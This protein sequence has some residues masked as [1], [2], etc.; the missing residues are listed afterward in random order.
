M[1][2]RSSGD[3]VEAA[4]VRKPAVTVDDL[5]LFGGEPSEP[6]PAEQPAHLVPVRAH[7]RRVPGEA[8]PSGK[9]LRDTALAAHEADEAKAVAIAYLRTELATLYHER[10][11]A[12]LFGEARVP[13]G[14]TADDIDAL[15]HRWS[16]CPRVLHEIPGH[17]KGAVFRGGEWTMTGERIRSARPHL[18]ATELPVW[19]LRED[20]ARRSA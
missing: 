15:L 10:R 16:A 18:R 19:A 2:R 8:P 12:S 17:W 3:E 9:E 11:N 4:R 14:V 20:A 7:L 5:P 1:T 13:V 6:A